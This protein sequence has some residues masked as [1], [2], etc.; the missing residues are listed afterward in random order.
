MK[1]ITIEICNHLKK[2]RQT[3]IEYTCWMGSI[4]NLIYRSIIYQCILYNSENL[5]KL[6]D[7]EHCQLI[8]NLFANMEG[9][10]YCP[11]VPKGVKDIY[12][13][14]SK[15][16]L[17]YNQK[18]FAP[19]FLYSILKYCNI[20]V[21]KISLISNSNINNFQK[22]SYYDYNLKLYGIEYNLI[23]IYNNNLFKLEREFKDLL[24][25]KDKNFRYVGMIVR[26][27]SDNNWAHYI[28]IINCDIN[29]NFPDKPSLYCDTLDPTC[30]ELDHSFI[31]KLNQKKW[32]ID[33]FFHQKNFVV[34]TR[35]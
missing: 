10:D 1:N 18:G 35:Q 6:E 32:I 30:V 34:T 31:N 5:P 9:A 12:E 20:K 7:R 26:V 4:H 16:K 24:Y 14:V 15:T 19:F 17:N 11:I 21:P 2:F 25:K 29:G 3:S 22:Q 27:V 23:K 13:S 28:S 33:V 8:I